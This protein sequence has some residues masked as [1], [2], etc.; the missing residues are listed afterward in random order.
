MSATRY[1]LSWPTGQPRTR[2][3][4]RVP[5]RFGTT[6]E[7][8]WKRPVTV[9]EALKRLFD[10]IGKYTR[11]GQ[12]YRINAKE[13]I[14]ST[15]IRT[16]LDGLPYSNA[17]EPDDPGVCVYFTLDGLSI[18]LPCDTFNRVADNIAAIAGH[19]SAD[20]MQERYGVGRASDRYAG[21]M[22]LPAA[23][24]GTG[25]P[26]WSVLEVAPDAPPESIRSAYK[27]MA[28][29]THPDKGGSDEAFHA[30]QE[31]LRQGLAVAEAPS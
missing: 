30:V 1:P 24:Q 25:T 14:V 9:S 2:P 10:E 11:V 6:G 20:R 15:N 29:K 16:R 21:Y 4:D 22:A 26:W 12:E 23:G 17:S 31:A 19:I 7:R 18:A 8:G 13:V 27:R 3:G 28:L 5:A